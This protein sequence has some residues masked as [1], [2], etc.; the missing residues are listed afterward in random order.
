M[1]GNIFLIGLVL[2]VGFVFLAVYIS[3]VYD[4]KESFLYNMLILA[5]ALFIFFKVFP[6]IGVFLYSFL[7]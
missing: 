4:N 1:L 6:L 5:G 7:K 2:F 3:E